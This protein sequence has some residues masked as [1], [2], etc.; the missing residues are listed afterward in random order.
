MEFNDKQK[1]IINS[2]NGAYLISAPVGTGKTTILT[3]RIIKALESGINPNEILCLTFTNRAADE[4]RERIRARVKDKNIFDSLT[5]STF[6][7]FCAYFIRSEAKELDLPVDYTILDEVEQTE[8]LRE[9]LEDYPEFNITNNNGFKSD[10]NIYEL[11]ENLYKRREFELESDIGCEVAKVARNDVLDE[12][13][14][15]YLNVLKSQNSLDFGELVLLTM[16]GLY[17]NEKLQK[18]WS[19]KFKFIQ[20]D[21]FQDTHLSEYLVVKELAKKHKNITLIGD[22]DQTIYS[23]RGSKPQFIKK[24][25]KSH[26][27][28][29]KELHLEI[30]YR[31]SKGVLD[32]VK[33]F[34]DNLENKETKKIESC[35]KGDNEKSVK[36]FPAYN[37]PEEVDFVVDTINDIRN[38]EPKARIAVLARAHYL[39]SL[40]ANI[41]KEK[42]IAHITVDQYDF[43][44]RQEIKDIYA[45]LKI[46][47]N[48][49]DFESAYRL[50]QRPGRGIGVK[51]L[52]KIREEGADIGIRV[53]DFLDF[54]NYNFL[55]PYANLISKHE[56][57]RIIVLD[58]ETTGTDVLK[59]EI[60]QIYAIEVVDG[61]PGKDFHFYLKNSIP[62]GGSEVVHGISDEFLKENGRI[63]LEVLSELKD[64]VNN[65][66]VVGHNINFDLNMITENSKR[67]GLDFEFKEFYDTLDISRRIVSS[68]NYKL[69]T[70]A[71]K[72]GLSTA[73][74]DARD[75]VLATV[76]LMAVLVKKLKPDTVKRSEV[77]KK[78]SS[79]FISLAIQISSWQKKA[80]KTRPDEMLVLVWEESGLKEFYSKDK[81]YDRRFDSVKTLLKLFK[82]KDDLGKPGD[83]VLRELIRYASLVKDIDFLGLEQGKIPI[84]TVHQVKGLEF[85]YVFMVGLN[86]F[87]FPIRRPGS[88]I[89]EEKRLFY[90]AMT[91]AR[92]RIFLTY[93][94]F[95]DYGSPQAKSPFIDFIDKKFV[96]LD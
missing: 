65:D 23:W 47:F 20:L 62:V 72:F 46:I 13:N 3:E 39:I 88:D 6:H 96:S 87:K 16:R 68:E 33:S 35:D 5:I 45:Y 74:H 60:I 1:T 28:P 50:S 8:I 70:L 64:F 63:P 4:M 75:D 27:S 76:G 79:K 25:F 9:I 56:K 59:D 37:L 30:N 84:V 44:R 2:V 83:V 29:V 34:L 42:G 90:V 48:K 36:V 81:E 12:I 71:E 58:T 94:Q 52:Q 80:K 14:K 77:F 57:G 55:E 54:K 51:T 66:I 15:K 21:E 11:K 31:F 92:K 41:F 40:V 82:D 32:A 69:N 61:K 85:D 10:F 93:S 17:Q 24:I 19:Q 43:F 26:F 18:K 89:E 53:S 78:F 49:Y 38:K 7:G 73:T 67:L 86:D 95:N 22:L 91:R